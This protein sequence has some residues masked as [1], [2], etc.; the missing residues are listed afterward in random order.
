ME[1]LLWNPWAVVAAA[2]LIVLL[3]S[4]L[5]DL[6]QSRRRNLDRVGFMPWPF[7]TVMSGIFFLFGT[8]LAIQTG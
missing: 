5:G 4:I 8:A 2:A 3:V 6:R 1:Q 7:L